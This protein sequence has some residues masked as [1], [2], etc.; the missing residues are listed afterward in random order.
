MNNNSPRYTDAD[1]YVDVGFVV[2]QPRPMRVQSAGTVMVD[3]KRV[4]VLFGMIVIHDGGRRAYSA[5]RL[6]AEAL[7]IISEVQP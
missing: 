3:G 1:P 5:L 7:D 6:G 2:H 4:S